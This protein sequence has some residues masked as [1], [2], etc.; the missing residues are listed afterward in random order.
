[1][2]GAAAMLAIAFLGL[3]TRARRRAG[4]LAHFVEA[5]L[6]P[7]GEAPSTVRLPDGSLAKLE[8]NSPTTSAVL[9]APSRGDT[10]YREDVRR[11]VGVWVA[12]GASRDEVLARLHREAETAEASA[13]VIAAWLSLPAFV[14]WAHGHVISPW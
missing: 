8:G 1:M 2:L 9:V 6:I 3:A 7:G 11:T 12:A 4:L 14:A 10:G 13:V 5:T